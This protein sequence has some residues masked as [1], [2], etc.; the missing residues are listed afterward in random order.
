MTGLQFPLFEYL[1]ERILKWRRERRGE[2]MGGTREVLVE[3]AGVTGVSAGLSGTVASFVTTPIDVVKTRVMLSA[4]EGHMDGKGKGKG[5]L[6]VGREIFG[7]EGVRGLFKGGAIRSGWT[8]V[9]VSLY[10]SIYES[11]RFFLEE[12]RKGIEGVDGVKE[13]DAVM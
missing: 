11:G 5:A 9:A 6:A 4:G 1:R 2:S 10:L 8:A 3:R 7:K 13:G 12:R